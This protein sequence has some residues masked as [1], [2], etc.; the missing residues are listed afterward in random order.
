MS[1]PPELPTRSKLDRVQE[2]RPSRQPYGVR[3]AARKEKPR[4]SG[5]FFSRHH[6]RHS[7]DDLEPTREPYG[8]SLRYPETLNSNGSPSV[9]SHSSADKVVY[10]ALAGNL[11]IAISKFGAAALTGSSAMLSEAIHSTVDTGNE[12]LLIFGMRRAERPADASHPFGYGLQ[13]YFWVFVV[14]VL[15]FGFGAVFSFI[16]GLRKI[17]D[18]EPMTNVFVNYIV[19]GLAILFEAGSWYVAFSEFRK[20]IDG[21]GWFRT[22]RRSK[23]PTIFAVLFEDTAAL[24]GLVIAL[25]G[26]ALGD[27]L[28][29]PVLDGV[30]SLGIALVLAVTAIFLGYESQSLLTG[31]AAYPEVRQG[32]EAIARAAPGVRHINQVLTMHFGPEQILAALSLDFDDAI[33]AEQVEDA[34][35]G[36]ER[37][38]KSEFPEV[39]R[40]FVEAKELDATQRRMLRV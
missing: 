15:I 18:P 22:V 34:V 4:A 21:R 9:A 35:A 1:G 2:R 16:E 10:A 37:S 13:L 7:G 5:A 11:A 40:I 17:S 31:E 27:L 19:L 29:L 20:Q 38:V 28:Q 23:D 39:T 33:R 8:R 32:I 12:L 14:A 36:I 25:V 24:I 26:I 6:V 3:S 30:A